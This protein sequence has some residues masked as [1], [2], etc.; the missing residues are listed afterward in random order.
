MANFANPTV[1]SNYTD[2][3]V[4]IRA[5]VDAALQQLS[6]G[7]HTNIPTGAIKFDTSANR[8][9][10]FNGSAFV[11]LTGTYDLNANVSVN[12]LNLGTNERAR[13]GNSQELQIYNDGTRSRVESVSDHLFIKGN[14]ITFFKGNTAEQFIDCNSD[15]SVDL[16]FNNS[17]KLSTD[18]NGIQVTDRVGI[19]RTAGQPLDVEGNAQIGAASTNDAEL[20]IGRSGSGNRNAFID[21][22]G[23][24]TYT[25]H[26]LRIIRHDTG[27]NAASQLIHRGTSGLALITQ[28]AGAFFI[29]TN[30]TTRFYIHPTSGRVGVG[31]TSVSARLHVQGTGTAD[32][33]LTLNANLGSNNRNMQILSPALDDVNEPFKFVTGNSFAFRVDST[34]CLKI[35]SDDD[36][37]IPNDTSRLKI[38]AGDDLQLYHSG[39]NSIINNNTGRLYIGGDDIRLMNNA[40]SELYIF[41]DGDGGGSSNVGNVSLYY[42]NNRHFRTVEPGCQV[43]RP[44]GDTYLV[45]NALEDNAATDAVLRLKV[46]NSEA[47]SIIQF[48]D[49][50]DSDVGQ[51]I[52]G[53][54]SGTSDGDDM[55]FRTNAAE[56]MRLDWDGADARLGV[57][58]SSPSVKL[59]VSDDNANNIRCHRPA[60][61]NSGIQ[62]SNSTSSVY[63]GLAGN[64]LGF[65]V[66][67]SSNNLSSSPA[68]FVSRTDEQIGIGT[69][70]PE[71][72]VHIL[73]SGSGAVAGLFIEDSSDS[74]TSPFLH[75]RG[76]RSDSNNSFSFGGQI[77]LSC[78]RTDTK[79]DANKKLGTILFGGNHTDSSTSNELFPASIFAEA[80]DTFDS[81][82]DMPTDLVFLPGAVGRTKNQTNVTA[83]TERLRLRND[84]RIIMS[85]D[86]VFV[87]EE[88]PVLTVRDTSTGVADAS[89]TLRL[90]ESTGGSVDNHFDLS[91]VTDADFRIAQRTGSGTANIALQI[92]RTSQN[93][94][95]GTTTPADK[96][97]VVGNCA[98]SGYL[99]LGKGTQAVPSYSFASDSNTGIFSHGTGNSGRLGITCNNNLAALF[100]NEGFTVGTGNT[101]TNIGMNTNTETGFAVGADG[102]R[103][104]ISSSNEGH[105]LS[106]NSETSS[107]SNVF[108]SFRLNGDVIGRIMQ[109]TSSTVTYSNTSDRR[110]K[111]N[112]VDIKDAL[113]TLLKLKPKQ[114]NWKKDVNK[115]SEHG[116]IAQDLLEDNVCD[117]AVSYDK[118]EDQ[119]GLD[120]SRLVTIAI[121]AIQELSSKVSELETKVG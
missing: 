86:D 2:F 33:L 76:K 3:P 82:T 99:R 4:E 35:G 8:W 91:L 34:D 93:I 45:I 38:G 56:Q 106:I 29:K 113:L 110:L 96:L 73:S 47:N 78:N 54:G 77:Y 9:K 26:G 13:F 75:I 28:D 62:F 63:A 11:D 25:D 10:K 27:P 121:A 30:N 94:G 85:S 107:T 46:S 64:A 18:N 12:Q 58:T 71:A 117:Y 36:V 89:A 103:V 1:G 31:L 90:A 84:G 104:R 70:S 74:S 66:N 109:A 41:C 15:G 19:G 95:L 115:K 100:F 57:G 92:D 97:S 119:Y 55:M 83:G 118:E 87:V 116:F 102:Q 48:G 53:H 32:Q 114:Y 17:K 65:A 14:D 6:V 21:F 80:A 105:F 69:T 108:A 59:H 61:N 50:S 67:V 16:F 112:I 88:N 43:E 42:N 20:I 7:S 79:I 111:E 68:F 81:A 39:T 22:I 120:Y 72:A 40:L 98:I 52:Y 23:D 51:I 5:S 24:N 37:R 44:T 60:A 49:D 101:E